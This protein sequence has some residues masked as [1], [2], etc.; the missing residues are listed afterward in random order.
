MMVVDRDPTK[1][2]SFV[3]S[4]SRRINPVNQGWSLA[5]AIGASGRE[6]P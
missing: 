4:G 3:P 2:G 5:D 6:I 1:A